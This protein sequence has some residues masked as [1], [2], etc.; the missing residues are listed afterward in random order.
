M[1]MQ[2]NLKNV[3]ISF[4]LFLCC[5][6]V[7]MGDTAENERMI[8]SLKKG[9]IPYTPVLRHI[10]GVYDSRGSQD[11]FAYNK[12]QLHVSSVLNH[13]G[14]LVEPVD[15][16]TEALPSEEEMEKYDA[17]ITWFEEPDISK[18]IDFLVWVEKQAM[19]GK[20]IIIMGYTGMEEQ[21]LTY[22]EFQPD[23]KAR[24]LRLVGLEYRGFKKKLGVDIR[25]SDLDRDMMEYEQKFKL[26]PGDYEWVIPY[27]NKEV[28]TWATIV[29]Q[30]RPGSESHIVTT[31][32]RGGYAKHGYALWEE[33]EAYAG[34]EPRYKWYIDPFL[35]FSEI[36]GKSPV[37]IADP[38]TKNGKRIFFS[39]VDGDAFNSFSL[40]DLTQYSSDILYK[41]YKEEI[42]HIPVGVSFIG[43]EVDPFGIKG[44]DDMMRD[45]KGKKDKR[46]NP[47]YIKGRRGNKRLLATAKKIAALPNI[48]LASHTYHHPYK[49]K[50]PNRTSAF[51]RTPFD[52]VF[53]IKGSID[54]INKY[55]APKG[56]QVEV[57]YWSGDTNPPEKA[58]TL[59]EKLKVKQINGGDGMYDEKFDSVAH[60]SPYVRKIGKH[61]QIHSCQSNENLYTNLWREDF[62]GMENV[63]EHFRRTES[64]RRL[65][66][67]NLYYHFYSGIR[68]TALNALRKVYKWAEDEGYEM[69]YP[70][71]YI[72]QV[73]GFISAKIYNVRRNGYLILDR[74]RLNNLRLDVGEVDI[75]RSRGVVSVKEVNDSWYISL[76]SEEKYPIIQVER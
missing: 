76:D 19:K 4:I 8:Q 65:A 30:K 56:K 1:R 18:P 32:P 23:I 3:I 25:I 50:D 61:W 46:G 34:S 21:E 42:P 52:Y 68:P 57:L 29:D 49:W 38:T 2:N 51:K 26:Y 74:G 27:K 45:P 17:I 43:A 59:L 71:E 31:S 41:F 22:E 70:T 72:A 63:L 48:Q 33:E 11:A 60:I 20:K 13:M 75:E 35:F 5:A 40:I 7:A 73:E 6:G 14:Y 54:F 64:P 47:V 9:S 12:I 39:H 28:K 37:P 62:N 10:L 24:L 15:M 67:A 36:L 44:S 69:V 58:F 16:R 55:I 53:E 66:C